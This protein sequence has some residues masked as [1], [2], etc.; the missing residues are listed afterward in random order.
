VSEQEQVSFH[1]ARPFSANAMWQRRL[2]RKGRRDLTPEYKRW[3]DDM[4]WAIKVQFPGGAPYIACCFDVMIILPPTRMDHD[5]CI[6]PILD[7]CQHISLISNDRNANEIG[8]RLM[9]CRHDCFVVLTLR[10][11][12]PTRAGVPWQQKPK[13]KRVAR[14]R[15]LS[16][17]GVPLP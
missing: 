16:S 12:I 17:Y 4:G 6:K 9:D 7:L 5:N 13:R 2:T 15:N 11:D 3:R 8:V 10:P 14:A 1:V